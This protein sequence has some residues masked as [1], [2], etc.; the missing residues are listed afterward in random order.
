LIAHVVFP[1]RARGFEGGTAGVAVSEG[2]SALGVGFRFPGRVVGRVFGALGFPVLDRWQDVVVPLADDRVDVAGVS[3]PDVGV[4]FGVFVFGGVTNFVIEIFLR[5]NDVI[6]PV[7]VEQA[8]P[9][10]KS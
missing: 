5:V 9:Q 7:A 2:L 3:G 4:G 10:L 8:D 1:R 6:V